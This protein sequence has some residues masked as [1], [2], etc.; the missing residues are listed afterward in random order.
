M[1]F[2]NY[3]SADSPPFSLT[4]YRRAE[5]LHVT[6]WAD[7]P[8]KGHVTK[9]GLRSVRLRRPLYMMS[10]TECHHL[11][12][13]SNTP[14]EKSSGCLSSSRMALVFTASKLTMLDIPLP[15]P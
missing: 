13:H 9:K 15:V 8:H 7:A 11:T 10:L 4:L 5:Q 6:R 2:G 1:L 3:F 12:L 14:H